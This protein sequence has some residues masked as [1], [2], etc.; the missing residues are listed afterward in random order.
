MKKWLAIIGG[1]LVTGL[2]ALLVFVG[3]RFGG[4]EPYSDLSTGP[5]HPAS[6]LETVFT[7]PEPLGNIAVAEDGRVFFT[8]HPESRPEDDKLMLWDGEGFSAFPDV[9]TQAS[10]QTPLGT[11]ID[12]QGRLW[13]IDHG[14]HGAGEPQLLAFD[15]DTGERVY[16]HAFDGEVAPPG[17]FLQDLQVSPDGRTVYIAD[18]GLLRDKPG[19]VIH[20][21]ETG[22]S[23]RALTGHPSVMPQDYIIRAPARDMVFFGGLFVLKPGVD[24]IAL[25]RDGQWLYYGAMTH[26][27]LY[28]VPT[29]VLDAGREP[30]EVARAV[31]AVGNKPLNDGMSTDAAGQI[32]LTDVEHQGVYVM[33]PGGEGRTLFRHGD[34]S[35]ADA[36]SFG[37]D[38]WLYVVDSGIPHQMLRSKAHMKAA[39]PYGVYR[40]RLAHGAPAGQ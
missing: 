39:G 21:T 9:S 38:N 19:L 2:A 15:I 28:R 40:L 33:T 37:P 18:L 17:S 1:I 11:V 25:S 30:A 10:L 27:T 35:W 8:I 13:V 26:E 20:D 31:E 12:R 5:L 6:A 29:S 24:G 14:F 22:S 23:H 32:Y 16:R 7:Y 34:I 36:L 3:M 4:G